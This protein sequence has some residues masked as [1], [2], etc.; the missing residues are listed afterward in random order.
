MT[1]KQI[2]L[3]IE[4]NGFEPDKIWCIVSL[5]INTKESIS[6]VNNLDQLKKDLT[7]V[8]EII[9]HNILGYDI[10]VLERLLGID[11][12]GIK[13]TDTLVLS[14]LT[15][16]ARQGGHSLGSWG[17]RLGYPKGDYTDFSYYTNEMLDYCI[18]DTEVNLFTYR[19]LIIEA[20][21]FSQQ[22]IDLE[23]DVHKIICQQTRSG[24]LLDEQ[25]AFM[26]LAELKESMLNAE[27]KVHERFVPLPVWVEKNYP[28]N[29]IKKDGTEAAIMVRH[30]EQGFHYDSEGSY[31]VF[32]Y[33]IFN[34]G[35]RQ[36]IGRYL[37]HF[38]WTPTEFTETGLPKID[39]KVLEG[40][41]VPE[42]VM[43]KEFLLLQKRVGMVL[44]WI[45]S[46]A[47]DGR[48]HGYVNS[49]GAQTGRMSHSSPNVAQVP[50]SYSP[51][52]KECRECWI[53]PKGYKLVGC[54][55]SGL[56][57]RMLAHYLKDEDYTHQILDGDI[58][59]YNMNMA[60]LS[61]RDQAKTFIYGFL[62][63]AGDAKI[64]E[65]VGGTSKHG[66]KIKATFFK[67]IPKLE[68]L[69]TQIK[70]ASGR[71]YLKGL[72]GRRIKVKSEHSAPNYLLQS[73]GAI[74]MKKALVLL[75]ASA[76]KENLDF[77]FVGNIHDEY[78][79]QVLE[80]HSERFGVLAVEAIVNAGLA[81]NMNCPLDG[82]SKIGNN[83][84]ECH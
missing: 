62:Y 61:N 16:P 1:S 17:E 39:E 3:D 11:F 37:I 5:D 58:H 71:G 56:E 57:L 15:N 48:V 73:A 44:S 10:P 47:D 45:E 36:Q 54:D 51:Y 76:S 79:T 63:G 74:V 65:I 20:N 60:G 83:W 43:I 7:S 72:D 64:G 13:L 12:S 30:R 70:S 27:A 32:E 77:T 78:Q 24:W 26:L 41:D 6:Y 59:T 82:E 40:V 2:V 33:P 81:L 52:G 28:K 50:A 67:S 75:Y 84:Y 18:K 4:A 42:A 21:G 38:G 53:V 8:S 55:A 22:S 66:K 34:L 14:R 25:K 69:I 46:V 80:K 23:M 68:K 35:S 31:G 49:I 19:Q 9:G 29:P